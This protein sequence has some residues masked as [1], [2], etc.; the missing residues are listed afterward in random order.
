MCHQVVQHESKHEIVPKQ[1]AEPELDSFG[2]V[3][4]SPPKKKRQSTTYKAGVRSEASKKFRAELMQLR[5]ERTCCDDK[6]N[7][8]T[9]ALERTT[10]LLGDSES[11]LGL[12]TE[13][14]QPK[15]ERTC[16]DDRVDELTM[17]AERAGMLLGDSESKLGNLWQAHNI[18]RFRLR[19]CEEANDWLAC[20]RNGSSYLPDTAIRRVSRN[21]VV[22]EIC[23]GAQGNQ[24]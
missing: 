4:A 12:E 10:M 18:L 11:M 8:L 16:C 3:D 5:E 2:L 13:L 15:E 21:A 22:R 19:S 6:V 1:E 14:A 20:R 17:A 23:A 7:E 9:L 24:L